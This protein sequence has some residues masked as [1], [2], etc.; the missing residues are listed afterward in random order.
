MTRSIPLS[1]STALAVL[2]ACGVVL[3]GCD[4]TR[5][6]VEKRENKEGVERAQEQTTERSGAQPEPEQKSGPPTT[7]PGLSA[8]EVVS[9]FE[10]NGLECAPHVPQEGSALLYTCTSADNQDLEPLYKGKIEGTRPQ[11]VQGA[12]V[13]VSTTRAGGDLQLARQS[14]LAGIASEIEYEGANGEEASDFVHHNQHIIGKTSTTIGGVEFIL[15]GSNK[16]K[17]LR[18]A[19]AQ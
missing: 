10:E 2:L 9:I 1:A 13:R 7:I 17:L 15:I 19:P 6:P 12:E 18:V 3:A 16:S 11:R 4:Q 5:P 8:G 14:I